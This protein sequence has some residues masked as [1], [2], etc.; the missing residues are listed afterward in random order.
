[1]TSVAWE[2]VLSAHVVAMAL[3]GE[4]LASLYLVTLCFYYFYGFP[5]MII[6]N[7]FWV[8]ILYYY[9]YYIFLENRLLWWDYNPEHVYDFHKQ[10]DVK[11]LK[12]KRNQK[13]IAKGFPVLGH[14]IS[15]I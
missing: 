8:E 7:M 9:Y 4:S 1:M 13:Q 11:S 5:F 12:T 10:E 2:N 3:N 6:N 14:I 15:I